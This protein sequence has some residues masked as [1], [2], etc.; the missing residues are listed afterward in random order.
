L[1][2]A[3]TFEKNTMDAKTSPFR[4]KAQRATERLEKRDALLRAAVRMF[5]SKGFFAT[6][7]DDVAASL[8]VSKPLIYHYLGNKDQVLFE[9]VMRGLDE[10]RIAADAAR[11]T[12]GHGLDRLRMFLRRYAEITMDD[13]GR[14]IV[15]TGDEALSKKSASRFRRLKRE[16]D[17]A[18]REL[19]SEGIADHSIG[20]ADVK[21]VAFT[22]AGALN[23][24]AR[25]Y[26]P[27]GKE[28][29]KSIAVKMVDILTA[30]LARR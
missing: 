25:W 7:L 5:N 30:G 2:T 27:K 16:I 9:C 1:P 3:R 29:A 20:P 17:T 26:D 18:M 23:W 11:A 12:P 14:C 8:N 4:S 21:L 22:L 24:P 28:T 19:I 15:R 13:F 10:L 6:S